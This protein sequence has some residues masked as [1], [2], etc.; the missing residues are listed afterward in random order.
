VTERADT[1]VSMGKRT[2]FW[3]LVVVATL[4]VLATLFW[5]LDLLVVH[6]ASADRSSHFVRTFGVP[7]VVWGLL[8]FRF[9]RWRTA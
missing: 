6:S 3:A 8:L 2:A 4:S 9:R 7:A 1:A 5:A